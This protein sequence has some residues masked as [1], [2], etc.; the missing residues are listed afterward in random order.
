[1]Q[2]SQKPLSQLLTTK[3]Y[4]KKLPHRPLVWVISRCAELRS[5]IAKSDHGLPAE[6]FRLLHHW[7]L[8]PKRG[9]P[10]RQFWAE[11]KDLWHDFLGKLGTFLKQAGKDESSTIRTSLE[12]LCKTILD[13]GL[14]KE[15][16]IRYENW[17]SWREE[18]LE[19]SGRRFGVI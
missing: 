10:F 13:V 5:L 14:P 18:A 7:S 9:G 15:S 12:D 16:T 3:H 11:V 1:M 19:G 6:A 4:A 17:T 8:L 2:F